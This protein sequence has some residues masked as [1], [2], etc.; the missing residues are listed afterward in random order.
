MIF[1][2]HLSDKYY[3]ATLMGQSDAFELLASSEKGAIDK[4]VFES[5][6]QSSIIK[7]L[8]LYGNEKVY[9][10]TLSEINSSTELT[11]RLR[12]LKKSLSIAAESTVF[13]NF[14]I[15][16]LKNKYIYFKYQDTFEPSST[17]DKWYVRCSLPF[18]L[19]SFVAALENPDLIDSEIIRIAENLFQKWNLG[20]KE[21]HSILNPHIQGIENLIKIENSETYFQISTKTAEKII[22]NNKYQSFIEAI[23]ENLTTYKLEISNIKHAPQL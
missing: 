17:H 1:T 16:L 2:A 19:T 20:E 5:I 18:T 10:T 3:I 21:I 11:S 7:Y 15:D 12:E 6:L 23:I 9:Q 22:M 8:D 14:N 4:E 13:K